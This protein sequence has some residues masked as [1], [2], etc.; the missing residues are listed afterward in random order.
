MPAL[1]PTVDSNIE[2]DGGLILLRP[3]GGETDAAS[4]HEAAR[5]SIAEVGPWL[6]WCHAE[7]SLDETVTYLDFCR[8]AWSDGREY[9]FAIFDRETERFLG[10]VG[11]NLIDW[12]HRRGNLGYWVRTSAIRRG[13]ASDAARILAK[14]GLKQLGLTRIEIVAAIENIASQRVAAKA[15]AAPEG[16]LRSRIILEG[17]PHDA[18]MFSF[19]LTDLVGSTG[20]QSADREG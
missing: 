10:G 2:L 3:I 13:H 5:E 15:G 19:V 8:Q 14:W 1:F 12:V 16:V 6:A 20:Q 7:Y 4:L 18:A 17:V 9:N 11:I